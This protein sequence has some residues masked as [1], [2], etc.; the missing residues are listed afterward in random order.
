[1]TTLPPMTTPMT[2]RMTPPPTTMPPPPMTTI[3]PPPPTTTVPLGPPGVCSIY[4]DPH[5]VTFD[6]KHAS[7]YTPGEYWIVKSSTVIIQGKYAALPSTNGLAVVKGLA[8]GGTF[9]HG[10][11]LLVST[12]DAGAV[13]TY[14]GAPVVSGFPGGGKTADGMVSVQYNQI[15]G[16]MDKNLHGKE[17]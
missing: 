6:H 9:L 5:V 8:I 13:V 1:M 3:P 4:G 11:K 2:T 15:G 17:R 14:D 12:M 10:H 16:L 7:Y